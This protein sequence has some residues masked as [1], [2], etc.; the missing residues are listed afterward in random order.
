MNALMRFLI[1]CVVLAFGVCLPDAAYAWG[2]AGHRF[3]T[4][5]AV[6]ELPAPLKAFFQN[7]KG[8][9][10]TNAATE[11]P[12]LH[13][14]DIDY[15]P[16]FFT[17]TFP[18]DASVLIAKYT[19][20]TVTNNG[21]APW[22]AADYYQT[23]RTRFAAA[24]TTAD[25]SNVLSTAGA[26]AH[27]LEDLHNPMHLATNYNGA[28]T[29][30]A[31]LHSRYETALITNRLAAGLQLATNPA[32]CIYYPSLLDAVFND[33]DLVYP[34][35]APLLAADLSAYTAAGNR[36]NNTYYQHL[37]DDGCSSFTP[38]VMQKAA[39]MVASAWYSAWRE[40]GF[41]Q[42][43]GVT[44]SKLVTQRLLSLGVTGCRLSFIGDAGQ[45]LELQTSTNLI[46]WTLQANI[47]NLDGHF[48][49]TAPPPTG[50]RQRFY[51]VVLK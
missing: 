33:I 43:P 44:A 7:Y 51:R 1:L 18:H 45:K 20:N 40:A 5:T 34:D 37:W 31:G 21:M 32:D 10:K 25:W 42:L 23:L 15:Y 6:E 17:H 4:D 39:G 46:A 28:Y 36:T 14:I 13:F 27:Y 26:M 41:P 12:G 47:T 16:E 22:T 3:I 49:F 24:K 9:I 38:V 8:Q 2:A 35:N 50:D 48:E 30:Q 29:G 11:P 19:A